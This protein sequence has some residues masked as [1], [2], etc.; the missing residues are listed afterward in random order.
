MRLL[1]DTQ[2][3]LWVLTDDPRLSEDARKLLRA[4]ATDVYYSIASLWEIA[5]KHSLGR[6]VHSPG[7]VGDGMKESGYQRLAIADEHLNRLVTLPLHHRDPFD[8]M[9]IAQADSEPLKLVTCD[10][11]LQAYGSSVLLV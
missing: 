11:L 6:F 5:I 2:V 10:R 3:V 7:S 4:P 8:R 1:L 9:L